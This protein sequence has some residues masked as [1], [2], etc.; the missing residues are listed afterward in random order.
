[1]VFI[2]DLTDGETSDGGHLMSNTHIVGPSHTNFPSYF[3]APTDTDTNATDVYLSSNNNTL[4]TMSA[5]SFGYVKPSPKQ[6]ETDFANRV[7]RHKSFFAHSDYSKQE[8]NTGMS[9]AQ[10]MA[11]ILKRGTNIRRAE[12]FHHSRSLGDFDHIIGGDSPHKKGPFADLK[13]RKGHDEDRRTRGKSVD[14]LLGHEPKSLSKSKSMEFLKA[15]L[16]SRK[17]STAHKNNSSPSPTPSGSSSSNGH[18]FR[19][20]D[21]D[22]RRR[23]D[24]EFDLRKP[25]DPHSYDWRQD[26]PFW[27]KTGRWARP[28]PTKKLIEEPWVNHHL[29]M[30]Q[31]QPYSVHQVP[32]ATKIQHHPLN[33]GAGRI[34]G[35]PGQQFPGGMLLNRKMGNFY[36]SFPVTA[37]PVGSG[38]PNGGPMS[39]HM[40]LAP[41]SRS[42]FPPPPGVF[43]SPVVQPPGTSPVISSS[44]SSGHS[45]SSTGQQLPKVK[46]NPLRSSHQDDLSSRLEITELTDEEGDRQECPT[47]DYSTMP[48]PAASQPPQPPPKPFAPVNPIRSRSGSSS[49][50]D[51][52]RNILDLP[53]GLY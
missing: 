9:P 10:R 41:N 14:R 45:S 19:S 4:E 49:A 33:G 43:C 12:S 38:S 32:K 31:Q 26:T 51:S 16:L 53:S 28:T 3:D 11:N 52:K 15:K 6:R 8:N 18:H 30:Q 21:W 1:M 23:Q 2:H 36:P 34:P 40:F 13:L 20:A 27:N 47:P 42:A 48:R 17:P 50:E 37:A 22:L 24:D 29:P 39:H 44:G 7:R 25:G 35:W 46:M 5:R